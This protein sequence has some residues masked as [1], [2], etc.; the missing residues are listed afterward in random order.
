[1]KVSGGFEVEKGYLKI[2]GG[3]EVEKGCLKVS[4]GSESQ[5]GY[6]K[7]FVGFAFQRGYLGPAE[8]FQEWEWG[9]ESQQF[10]T[11]RRGQSEYSVC[12]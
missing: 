6:L 3:F 10:S 7:A 5:R 4:G 2:S 12:P 9:W 11:A 1:L 8:R